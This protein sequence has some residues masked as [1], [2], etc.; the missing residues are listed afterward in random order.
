MDSTQEV[1]EQKQ[2]E[3]AKKLQTVQA[4]TASAKFLLGNTDCVPL[5]AAVS[6]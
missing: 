3:V 2:A 6:F 5:A 4:K 1:Q